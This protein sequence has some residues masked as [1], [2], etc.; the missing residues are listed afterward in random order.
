MSEQLSWPECRWRGGQ[1]IP[2]KMKCNSPKLMVA[3]T[4]VSPSTCGECYCRNHEPP[5]EESKKPGRTKTYYRKELPCIHRG[6]VIGDFMECTACPVHLCKLGGT[7]LIHRASND[8][9]QCL[10]CSERSETPV[11]TMT[12]PLTRCEQA[13]PDLSTEEMAELITNAPPGPWPD[14]WTGWNNVHE[15]HLLLLNTWEKNHPSYPAA[16]YRGRGIVSCVSAKPGYSSGK[17]LS[18]GYFPGAWVMVKELRRLGCLLPITFCHLG[19][20]EWDPVL[21]RLVSEYNV[22]VIDLRQWE[23]ENGHWRILAG[24]ESKIAA[25]LAAP[26]EEV[27]FLDADNVPVRDPSY[28]FD[29]RKYRNTGAILWPDLPPWQRPEWLPKEAWASIG[30]EPNPNV[31]DAESGQVLINKAQCWKEV[32]VCRWLNE[33]SD[34]YYAVVFGDKSTF[35]LAWQRCGSDYAMPDHAAGWNGGAILQYGFKGELLFEHGAQ[36]KPDLNDYPRE[37]CLT[38]P[39]EIADHLKELREKWGGRLWENNEPTPEEQATTFRLEGKTFLYR[40]IGLGER[41]LRF[42]QDGRI[43]RGM[44]KCEVSWSVLGHILAVGDIDGKPTMLLQEG[45]DGVWRG[46]W[47]DHEKCAVEL[48]PQ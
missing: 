45:P 17:D 36:N 41:T 1:T 9:K 43:G 16:K 11:A 39:G 35:T 30:L 29:E 26:Y 31:I 28:L 42:V 37:G 32:Q 33:H 48:I 47:L 15:A 40:R 6:P 46:D 34:R 2:G 44:A 3:F 18:H 14:G 4:G 12:E 24:W 20:L 5:P 13:S 22:N 23:K 21:T 10:S 19:P 8:H 25:I 7:C 38:H 27:L